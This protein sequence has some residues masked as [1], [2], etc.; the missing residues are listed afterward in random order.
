MALDAFQVTI[1]PEV[2]LDDQFEYVV[3]IDSALVCLSP[4]TV[5]RESCLGIIR[6][7]FPSFP[8]REF[9][10]SCHC[11]PYPI[12]HRDQKQSSEKQKSGLTTF[13]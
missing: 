7:Y 10:V 9:E 8:F 11:T 5:I 3:I 12:T 13:G 6:F 4:H 2:P 1:N